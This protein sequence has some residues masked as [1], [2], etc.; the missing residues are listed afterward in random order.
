MALNK[1]LEKLK[2]GIEGQQESLRIKP[3]AEVKTTPLPPISLTDL[4]QRQSNTSTSYREEHTTDLQP[5]SLPT[6]LIS[7]EGTL[8]KY[9]P[10][11]STNFVPRWCQL[12]S[13]EFRYY[14]NQWHARVWVHRPLFSIS[15]KHILSIKRYRPTPEE[16]IHLFGPTYIHL[17]QVKLTEDASRCLTPERNSGEVTETRPKSRQAWS[18]RSQEW[19]TQRLLFCAK[20][21]EE[22]KDW[23]V[24]FACKQ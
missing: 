12:T 13:T 9:K 24:A 3:A 1:A 22:V 5:E 21:A 20:S 7:L 2:T 16:K 19:A 8:L 18:S 4:S 10:G 6:G 14:K 11:L 17:F 15:L 23:T